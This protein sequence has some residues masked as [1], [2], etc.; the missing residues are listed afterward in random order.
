M[1]LFFV[2][3]SKIQFTLAKAEKYPCV[4][5][6]EVS[7]IAAAA[8]SAEPPIFSEQGKQRGRKPKNG[9][10][11]KG[12]GRKGKKGS[13]GKGK[14]GR[15]VLKN[16]KKKK[17]TKA[18]K[19]KAG[20]TKPIAESSKRKRKAKAVAQVEEPQPEKPKPVESLEPVLGAEGATRKPPDHVTAHHVYSSAYRKAA[21][22]GLDV[23]GR[24]QA[25][26]DAAAYFNQ[27]GL[28]DDRCGVFRAQPRK[29]N[30]PKNQAGDGEKPETEDLV[31]VVDAE[32]AGPSA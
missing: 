30:T 12:K 17:G 8:A 11:K 16:S 14:R 13:L 18:S 7:K 25:G 1:L 32:E 15:K 9:N 10:A 20:D 19:A 24:R 31:E 22:Q 27:T 6:Q 23:E 3:V 5:P 29:A 21:S 28:V 26:K 4:Q 2:L